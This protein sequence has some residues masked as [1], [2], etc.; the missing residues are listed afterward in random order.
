MNNFNVNTHLPIH[1]TLRNY[2]NDK[3]GLYN[4]YKK[5][6]GR[7]YIKMWGCIHEHS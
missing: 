7:K 4:L 2:E 1:E 3:L 6:K 5:R